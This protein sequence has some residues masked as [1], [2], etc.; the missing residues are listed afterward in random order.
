MSLIAIT[1]VKKR[2]GDNEV[3]KGISID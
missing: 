1:E 3:L 2:F